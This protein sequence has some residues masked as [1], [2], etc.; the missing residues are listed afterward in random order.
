MGHGHDTGQWLQVE[1]GLVQLPHWLNPINSLCQLR[2]S[3]LKSLFR[4]MSYV[5]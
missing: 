2:I 4:F 5:M 1:E 3:V